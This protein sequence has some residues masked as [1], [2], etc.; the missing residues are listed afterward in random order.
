MT[1]EARL[2]FI[3]DLHVFLTFGRK[4]LFVLFTQPGSVQ[5][6]DDFHIQSIPRLRN[7]NRGYF[8]IDSIFVIASCKASTF[9]DSIKPLS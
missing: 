5:Y 1:S 2:R 7:A 3:I 6:T 8:Q 4:A 9:T